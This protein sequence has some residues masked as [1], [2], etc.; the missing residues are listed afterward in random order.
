VRRRQVVHPRQHQRRG[1]RHPNHRDDQIT[2]G[3]LLMAISPI[4]QFHSLQFYVNCV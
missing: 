1:K 3:K 2:H 4:Y